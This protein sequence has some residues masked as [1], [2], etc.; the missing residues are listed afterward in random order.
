MPIG[1]AISGAVI[2]LTKGTYWLDSLVALVIGLVIAYHA[3][4]LVHR[5]VSDLRDGRTATAPVGHRS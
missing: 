1:V 2:L 4:K 5:V 3:L